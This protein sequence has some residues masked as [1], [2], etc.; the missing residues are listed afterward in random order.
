MDEQENFFS[1][2]HKRWLSMATQPPFFLSSLR[3]AQRKL[4]S[5]ILRAL[6][7]FAVKNLSVIST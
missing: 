5:F 7:A 4:S 3:Q 1:A 6:R 2:N